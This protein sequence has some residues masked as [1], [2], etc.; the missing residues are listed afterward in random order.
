MLQQAVPAI[1]GHIIETHNLQVFPL[2]AVGGRAA[3]DLVVAEA[4]LPTVLQGRPL[5]LAAWRVSREGGRRARDT[6]RKVRSSLARR[7]PP[8]RRVRPPPR[9][10]KSRS[11]LG[12]HARRHNAT[13][14]RQGSMPGCRLGCKN[15]CK[16]PARPASGANPGSSAS[17]ML[18]AQRDRRGLLGRIT[19]SVYWPL[20]EGNP[21][22]RGRCG[23]RLSGATTDARPI[24]REAALRERPPRPPAGP[25]NTGA[26]FAAGR[27]GPSRSAGTGSSS[28]ASPER[29]RGR[30]MR[31][32]PVLSQVCHHILVDTYIRE[33]V[34]GCSVL[35]RLDTDPRKLRCIRSKCP[36][37]SE[38]GPMSRHPNSTAIGRR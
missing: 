20:R 29:S 26:A 21:C 28:P 34:R 31:P 7:K 1:P 12:A 22:A 33:T 8:Q 38:S 32:R 5:Q 24:V 30:S 3:H 23:L 18:A 6:P 27:S 9:P 4:T 16:H 36:P 13:P 10:R 35:R 14:L 11:A 37:Q 25:P 15:G 19:G 17:Q 2:R